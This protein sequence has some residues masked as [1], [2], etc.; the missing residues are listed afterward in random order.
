M[1]QVPLAA[2][3]PRHIG[4]GELLRPVREVAAEDDRE[5]PQV[6][7]QVGDRIAGEAG[8]CERAGQQRKRDVVLQH[9]LAGLLADLA[10]AFAG[11]GPIGSTVEQLIDLDVVQRNKERA[12]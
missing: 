11:R 9:L 10:Q 12:A 8:Q 3:L 6:A 1:P 5:G 4:E 2:G 7:R